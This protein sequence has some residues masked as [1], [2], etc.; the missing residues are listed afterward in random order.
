MAEAPKFTPVVN[1][2]D[3]PSSPTQAPKSTPLPAELISGAAIPDEQEVLA[4]V[5]ANP[6]AIQFKNS[7]IYIQGGTFITLDRMI[8]RFDV[9]LGEVY[10]EGMKKGIDIAKVIVAAHSE[11]VK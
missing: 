3:A 9:V 10:T 7:L 2:Q 1:T 4:I 11:E 8:A 6:S 5:K